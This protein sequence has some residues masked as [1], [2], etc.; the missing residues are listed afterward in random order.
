MLLS[1]IMSRYKLK[2]EHW[3]VISPYLARKK[4]S[5]AGRPQRVD[6]RVIFEGILWI[7]HTGAS[8]RDLPKEFGAW[9]TVYKMFNRWSKAQVF[10]KIFDIFKD[11]A[12]LDFLIIDS[13]YVKVHKHGT[14]PKG[15]QKKKA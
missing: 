4:K 7:L 12:E 6:D 3:G 1:F 2:D 8:W 14:N 9:Q 5:K 11:N 15:G 10:D 13:S